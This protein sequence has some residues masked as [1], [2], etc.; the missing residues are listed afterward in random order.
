MP[1]AP[2]K[3]KLDQ[4]ILPKVE[5]NGATLEQALEYLRTQSRKLDKSTSGEKGVKIILRLDDT[6]I[7]ESITLNVQDLPLSEAI[8]YVTELT[9]TK[10]RVEENS[11]LIVP[12]LAEFE[13]EL[14]SRTFKVPPDFLSSCDS[15]YS[16][17]AASKD[18]FAPDDPKAKASFNPLTARHALESAGVR[19]S[20]GAS[21][22]FY[23]HTSQLT[24][25]NT[26]PNLD[27]VEGLIDAV[28]R[29][30]P[31][32]V[33]FTLTVIEG[34]AELIR[35]AN[36]TAS[37]PADASK[38]LTTLLAQ[39]QKPGSNVRVIS[40]A[41]LETKSGVRS[42]VAT[43]H[44]HTPPQASPL[45]AVAPT[46]SIPSK[47]RK[48]GLQL[49]IEPIV[50][51]DG[52]TIKASLNLTL[53]ASPPSTQQQAAEST[54]PGDLASAS[55]S[56]DV[57]NIHL[58]IDAVLQDGETSLISVT[59]PFD[60]QHE[61]AATLCAVFLTAKLRTVEALPPL[62]PQPAPRTSMPS[63]MTFFALHAPDGLFDE[64]LSLA[65]PS[66]LKPWLAE[67][68]ITFPSGSSIEQ[69]GDQLWLV[70]TPANISNIASVVDQLL[71]YSGKFI[72]CTLHTL[73]APAPILRDLARHSIA[74]ADDSAM[75]TAVEAAVAR[76]EAS[77]IDSAFLPVFSDSFATRQSAREQT[78]VDDS[79]IKHQNSRSFNFTP[80]TVG[81][82]LNITATIGTDNHSVEVTYEHELHPASQHSAGTPAPG[83]HYHKTSTTSTFTDGSIRLISLTPPPGPAQS[84]KLWAT[85]LKCDVVPILI[86]QPKLSSPQPLAS[87]SPQ[88]EKMIVKYFTFEDLLSD[89]QAPPAPADGANPFS[90]ASP[91][92]GAITLVLATTESREKSLQQS[93]ESC[94][95]EFPPGSYVRMLE[96]SRGFIVRNT[97]ANLAKIP[98][99]KITP[100]S[101]VITTHMFQAPGL[102]L[103]QLTAHAAR[104]TNHRAELNQL[105]AAVK[106]GEATSLVTARF[107]AVSGVFST[108]KQGA[109]HSA[110]TQAIFTKDATPEFVSEHR[111]VG[112]RIELT[113][114]IAADGKHI[115]LTIAAEFDTAPPLEHREHAFDAQGLPIEFTLTDYFIS[116]LKTQITI[117]PGSARL[118]SLY[119]P[120]GK[121]EFEKDDIL[122]AIFITCDLLRSGE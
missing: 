25:T 2:L 97:P 103:R 46:I 6:P 82:I 110:L 27:L 42:T 40:D 14:H 19:F 56:A 78:W 109:D 120:T 32:N 60:T 15:S 48:N 100:S 101:A 50:S 35:Q 108:L 107:E 63:G 105:L 77:Y 92:S 73:E 36:A 13:T 47:P 65:P 99:G 79:G 91:P 18:P 114:T 52:S 69:H 74:S 33:A 87:S 84:G 1:K 113:P 10:Y 37:V 95:A 90:S 20:K 51:T 55:P 8:R 24:V 98:F 28:H 58:N 17:N 9:Q 66:A 89:G 61:K 7:T 121:T 75:F 62:Q 53:G 83:F 30:A 38:E 93:F 26:Q 3:Q 122:Q 67:R 117:S 49:A 85:F 106:A 21:A 31:V 12:L 102:L 71:R 118:L 57:S 5:F 68:G 45:G 59:S 29:Q 22:S 80:R 88:P 72:A 86:K 4:I 70:N 81:S 34:P 64:V 11:V 16:S 104:K 112:L 43:L 96:Q 119:K 23:R 94:G 41:F 115:D 39:A 54:P 116:K 44:E 76:G 111:N